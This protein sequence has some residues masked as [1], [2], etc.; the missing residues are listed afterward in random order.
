MQ[1]FF[2]PVLGW[3][4]ADLFAKCRC[5]GTLADEAAVI[6]DFPNRFPG[7]D[8][9]LPG[10]VQADL[11]Q[12]LPEGTPIALLHHTGQM[13]GRD[14]KMVRQVLCADILPIMAGKKIVDGL[15]PLLCN[16]QLFSGRAVMGQRREFPD[17]RD[18]QQCQQAP[19]AAVR[20]YLP[21]IDLLTQ[22]LQI[23]INTGVHAS[24]VQ[25]GWTP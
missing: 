17:H 1:S 11:Q 5:E 19:D 12:V 25:P 4:A 22:Y 21:G 15:F 18:Q 16:G 13:P 24:W 3:C 23:P 6:G 2:H 9:P 8:Q 10:M 7:I 20:P 14:F